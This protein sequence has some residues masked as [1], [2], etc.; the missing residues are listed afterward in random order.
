MSLEGKKFQ[1]C[2]AGSN[3]RDD[4]WK[5]VKEYGLFSDA[6]VKFECTEKDHKFTIES[7]IR[8]DARV[9]YTKE[10]EKPTGSF[11]MIEHIQGPKG[12]VWLV[13]ETEKENFSINIYT[14]LPREEE[15][16]VFLKFGISSTVAFPPLW[17]IYKRLS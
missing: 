7:Y 16:S 2:L 9:K 3:H 10:V 12:E 17:E 11:K 15:K 1:V 5:A 14:K 4:M 8:K 6:D 13:M